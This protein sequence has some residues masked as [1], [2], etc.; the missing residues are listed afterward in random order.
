[1]GSDAPSDYGVGDNMESCG[2]DGARRRMYYLEEEVEWPCSWKLG[3]VICMAAN[4]DLGKVAVARNGSWKEAGCGVLLA[5]DEFK[6]PVY[7][8]FSMLQGELRYCIEAPFKYSPP[9]ADIWEHTPTR[10]TQVAV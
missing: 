5:G 1:M 4:V 9:G 8:A 6:M 3:D 10:G 7:P 2:F